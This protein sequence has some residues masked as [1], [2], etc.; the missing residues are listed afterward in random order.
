V[1]AEVIPKAA[2]HEKGQE[3]QAFEAPMRSD[4]DGNLNIEVEIDIGQ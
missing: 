4:H 3:T 1:K 2:Q